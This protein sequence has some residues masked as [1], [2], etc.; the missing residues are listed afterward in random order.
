[1][2]TWWMPFEARPTFWCSRKRR[3]MGSES[4]SLHDSLTRRELRCRGLDLG[5]GGGLLGS[6]SA[7]GWD[8]WWYWIHPQ[9]S[10]AIIQAVIRNFQRL[11][12]VMVI[13]EK[14]S[15]QGQS[16]NAVRPYEVATFSVPYC[17][18]VLASLIPDPPGPFCVCTPS[19]LIANL[20]L[21]STYF[22]MS[23]VICRSYCAVCPPA[24]VGAQADRIG[25]Q[26]C[27]C[28]S[29]R[30]TLAF[31][32]NKLED[33]YI[34]R[35]QVQSLLLWRLAALLATSTTGSATQI[36]PDSHFNHYYKFLVGSQN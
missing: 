14:S 27:R 6:R 2:R 18:A 7:L 33:L 26:V 9:S 34:D 23:R 25:V 10:R 12:S 8:E 13:T 1:M 20:S 36:K 29:G 28:F 21:E 32:K 3:G 4:L 35:C 22:N 19:R 15:V 24:H 16:F 11:H 17:L 30:L 5:G 31:I